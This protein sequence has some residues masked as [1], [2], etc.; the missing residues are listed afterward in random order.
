MNNDTSYTRRDINSILDYLKEQAEKLSEGRWTDFSAGDI[1]SVMLG[2]MATLADMNN[3]QIDK[4]AAELFL[5]TAVERTSVMSLLKLIGYKPRHYQSASCTVELVQEDLSS[6]VGSPEASVLPR[7]STFINA[8]GTITYTTLEPCII[9][10]GKGIVTAYEGTRVFKSFTYDNI[11]KDGRVYLPDYKLGTNTI[12]VLIPGISNS[13]LEQVYDVRFTDGTFCYSVHVDEYARVYIQLPS[14]W[15][16]LLTEQSVVS[17]SYLLTQGEAGR[18]GSN[19]L[20]GFG[21]GNTLLHN[22]I[23]TNPKKSIGGFFPETIDEL[24]INAPK[25]ARTMET[26]VTKKDLEDLVSCLPNIASIKCGDYN[27]DWTGYEQPQDAYK[28]K[29]LAVPR[30]TGELSLFDTEGN[31]TETCLEMQKYIDARRLAS[32]MMFYEDPKRKVPDIELN[33]YMDKDNLGIST[34]HTRVI[35]T[36]KQLYSR[37][38]LGIGNSLHGSVI[39]KDILN[40]YS[41][42]DYLEVQAPEYNIPCD[43][44]EYIDIQYSR[45]K[46]YVNDELIMNEWEEVDHHDNIQGK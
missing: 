1:G 26:I 22:Y 10:M 38:N 42:I 15:N 27:D 24:K 11:T 5:D 9:T 12:Q 21:P 17:I 40:A 37:H 16:D 25:H 41:E 30:N 8:S 29:V 6:V 33:I 4:T 45:F 43:K 13:F 18:I 44:D 20:V 19:I 39:G 32:I 23:V 7:Y 3:F 36:I 31:P 14:F 2:L 35:N 28:C 34:I 46:V